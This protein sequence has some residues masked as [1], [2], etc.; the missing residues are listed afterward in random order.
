MQTRRRNRINGY[1]RPTRASPGGLFV[2]VEEAFGNCP[3]YITRRHFSSGGSQ[4]QP[5]GPP[6]RSQHLSASQQRL[7]AQSDMLFVATANPG[8]GADASHRGGFPGFVRVL[9]DR[10]LLWPDY[11]GNGMFMVSGPI[12]AKSGLCG[13]KSLCP[14][15]KWSPHTFGSRSAH[16][17]ELGSACTRGTVQPRSFSTCKDCCKPVI[18]G[19]DSSDEARSG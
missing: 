3:K 1:S 12:S 11:T 16:R 8:G 9:D 10:T 15:E 14:P 5:E 4:R 7:I 13:L 6:S 17:C 2:Q 19:K 18:F